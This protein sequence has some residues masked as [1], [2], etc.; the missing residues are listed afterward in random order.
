MSLQICEK[1]AL[2]LHFEN[3]AFSHLYNVET[4]SFQVQLY[5]DYTIYRN[6]IRS[7][8]I[9]YSSP[10]LVSIPIR[11]FSENGSVENPSTEKTEEKKEK[12]EKKKS[13]VGVLFV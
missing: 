12:K 11:L 2:F 5:L 1:S 6:I 9:S 4:N 7:A 13:N 8:Q 10:K 3:I